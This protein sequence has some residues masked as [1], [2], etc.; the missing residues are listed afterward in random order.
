MVRYRDT[1]SIGFAL[2]YA[3]AQKSY[4]SPTTVQNSKKAYLAIL[5]YAHQ[6]LHKDP[7]HPLQLLPNLC[8]YPRI[9]FSII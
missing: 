5:K 2:A 4:W 8:P 9:A 3:E 6:K 7:S 1:T